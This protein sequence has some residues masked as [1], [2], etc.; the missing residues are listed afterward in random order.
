MMQVQTIW[1]LYYCDP[2]TGNDRR[3]QSGTEGQ[4]REAMRVADARGE[5]VWLVDPTGS[6]HLPE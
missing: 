4:M 2:F 3:S 1:K 5:D 6:K